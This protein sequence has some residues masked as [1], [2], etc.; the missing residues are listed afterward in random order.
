VSS[1]VTVQ[2]THDTLSL[3]F[4]EGERLF[5]FGGRQGVEMGEG[6]LGDLWSFDLQNAT[7]THVESSNPAPSPRSFHQMVRG[8]SLA[9]EVACSMSFPLLSIPVY[10]S[11]DHSG[12]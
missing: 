4:D 5:V 11:R 3:D 6:A 1:I 9:P 8:A 10:G 2:L 12:R 7:W